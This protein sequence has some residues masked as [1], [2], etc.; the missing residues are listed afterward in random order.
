MSTEAASSKVADEKT[1][2]FL[3]RNSFFLSKELARKQA[4]KMCMEIKGSGRAF[5][6]ISNMQN[7]NQNANKLEISV[8]D[9]CKQARK[10]VKSKSH[11]NEQTNIPVKRNGN[12]PL[13]RAGSAN[14]VKTDKSVKQKR[15]D[16]FDKSVIDMTLPMD[17]N[18]RSND[19]F[20]TNEVLMNT[21]GF[22]E[23]LD[24]LGSVS[25]E[26][27]QRRLERKLDKLQR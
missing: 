1:A 25:N 3:E 13:Y 2:A 18:F 11:D 6:P 8:K 5:K 21:I 10:N 17:F 12:K 16:S 4:L 22:I 9:H 24:K 7:R 20:N 19:S 23:V 15:N 14:N 26:D 27:L